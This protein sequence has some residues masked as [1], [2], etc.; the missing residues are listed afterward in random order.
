MR[1]RLMLALVVILT[2]VGG[3]A[4]QA[5][6]LRLQF[7]DPVGD[8]TSRTDVLGMDFTFDNATGAY[9]IVFAA[10]VAKP[11]NG[12]FRLN[13]NLFNV[14]RN[15]SS[16]NTGFFSDILNDYDLAS[17]SLTMTLN[18]TNAVLMNWQLGDRVAINEVAF[19]VPA[20]NPTIITAFHS[21]VLDFLPGAVTGPPWG[22]ED[23]VYGGTYATVQGVPDPGS[24]LVLMGIGILGLRASKKRRG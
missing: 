13:V 9:T 12:H 14:D 7:S 16:S 17:P 4:A 6:P 2:L 22:G 8:G 18:G 15:S 24:T 1:L 20:Y 5:G 3:A 21:E 23:T 11:F 19:G 10:T